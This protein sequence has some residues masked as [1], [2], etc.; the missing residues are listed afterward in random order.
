MQTNMQTMK[1]LYDNFDVESLNNQEVV[2]VAHYDLDAVGATYF[3]QKLFNV[4]KKTCSGYAK[5]L[6]KVQSLIGVS[7]T[8]VFV[9]VSADDEIMQCALDNF[10]KVYYADH[11]LDSERHAALV[12]KYPGKFFYLFDHDM[13]ASRLI[14]NK[15]G[16][17]TLSGAERQFELMVNAYD[18]WQTDTKW[19]KYGYNLNTLF[20]DKHF[21]VFLGWIKHMPNLNKISDIFDYRD[22]ALCKS[23]AKETR[24]FLL[25]ENNFERV[26][27]SGITA[28]IYFFPKDK[29]YINDVLL[30]F[31]DIDLAFGVTKGTGMGSVRTTLDIDMNDILKRLKDIDAH[32]IGGGGHAKACGIQYQ[33][34]DPSM[35]IGSIANMMEIIIEDLK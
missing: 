21:H 4:K 28:L 6:G 27:D 5:M 13:C 18:L 9:D 29:F 20:W 23:K 14:A 19:F 32:V 1:P 17:D 2:L 15:L 31:T 30:N 25:D 26:E 24:D 16:F 8:I 10:D 12:E 7:D 35:I 33:E 3:A 11:H 22:I 34:S